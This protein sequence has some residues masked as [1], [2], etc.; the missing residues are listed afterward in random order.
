MQGLRSKLA[1]GSGF[2]EA[3]KVM[4]AVPPNNALAFDSPIAGSIHGKL[5]KD[6]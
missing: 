2:A 3:A 5:T 6:H 4:A 1:N